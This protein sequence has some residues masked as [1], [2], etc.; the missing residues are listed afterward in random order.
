MMAL[1]KMIREKTFHLFNF[2]LF[3]NFIKNF[4]RFARGHTHTKKTCNFIVSNDVRT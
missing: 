1:I 4:L 3:M 2:L